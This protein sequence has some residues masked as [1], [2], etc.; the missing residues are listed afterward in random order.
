MG[1]P[2]ALRDALIR[3]ICLF[4]CAT[5]GVE[6]IHAY[7]DWL[8]PPRRRRLTE[9][10]ESDEIQIVNGNKADDREFI[11]EIAQEVWRILYGKPRLTHERK[12]R[13]QGPV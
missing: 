4:G 5:S 6:H 1:S 10:R 3:R 12:L 8:W 11:I 13:V 2:L 7:H 9:D